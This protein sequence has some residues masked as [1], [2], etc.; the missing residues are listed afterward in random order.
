MF[1]K[2]CLCCC[3][4]GCL[5]LYP[6]GCCQPPGCVTLTL[7]SAS[8]T[9]PTLLSNES[10]ITYNVG[11]NMTTNMEISFNITNVWLILI[12]VYDW[13]FI[14]AGVGLCRKMKYSI[15]I[16]SRWYWVHSNWRS[17]TENTLTQ[18]YVCLLFVNKWHY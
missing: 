4:I 14:H 2:Q 7:Y 11:R 6:T 18:C 17:N 12:M 13:L 9:P 15:I 16:Q 3:L 10:I 8:M 5:S 1:S